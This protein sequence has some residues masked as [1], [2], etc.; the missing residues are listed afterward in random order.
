MKKILL[1]TLIFPL[2]FGCT[3]ADEIN[4]YSA[5]QEVLMKPLINKFEEK[6]GIKVN[7]I[8]AKA[9]Q[10][11]NR[12]IQEGEYSNADI[13]LTTDVGRLYAAKV[14]NIMQKVNSHK[15]EKLIPQR[16]RDSEGYWFGLSL[17]YRIIVYDKNKV[18]Y[19]NFSGYLGLADDIWNKRILVRSSNNVYNQSLVAAMI[20]NYGEKKTADFLTKFIKNLARKP[21]G[22]DRDQIRAILGGEGDI[23]LVNSYYFL[24]MKNLDKNN[25]LKNLEAYFP[26]DDSMNTHI[27]I[28]GAGIL[29]HSKN[30]KNA[31]KF[32]EFL[33]E[34]EA[35]KIYAE[36]NYEYPIRNSIILN[37]FMKQYSN[38]K[39]DDISIYEVGELNKKAI[40]MMDVAG[41]K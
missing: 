7:I 35:Q 23:A 8:A 4:V 30:K 9:N 20:I 37:K 33:V 34:D 17:R 16:F 31:I 19:D 38:F 15:L 6:T 24:K 36:V 2:V 26:K 39:K 11:I 21:S 18:N 41:W 29:K 22:G 3:A 32:I 40:I 14:K 5:R 25:E 10:L 27:N 1:I 28:S 12:I 13:I